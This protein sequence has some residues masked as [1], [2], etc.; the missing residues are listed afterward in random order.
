M[1]RISE[2]ALLFTHKDRNLQISLGK[3]SREV[4]KNRVSDSLATA[5]LVVLFLID[6]SME[7]VAE[8]CV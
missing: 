4:E 1:T 7:K 8:N 5:T 6:F 3:K 2:V